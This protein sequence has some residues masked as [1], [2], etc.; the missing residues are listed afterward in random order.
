MTTVHQ[1]RVLTHCHLA[2][3]RTGGAAYGVV[4]DGAVAISGT[5]IVWVGA[6]TDVPAEYR[7]WAQIDLGGRWVL[8]AFIDC[9][10]HLVYAGHRMN[11]FEQR[12]LGASYADIA[13][14]GG[15]ILSTVFA[16]RKASLDELIKQ[17]NPRLTQ[18]IGFGTGTVEIKSGYGLTVRDEIKMLTAARELGKQAQV[19]VSTSFLGAHALPPEFSGDADGYVTMITDEMLPEIAGLG[20]ADAVDGFCETIGFSRAQIR[21]ILEKA[22]D[23]GLPIRLH[24]EQLSH[25]GGAELAA[26]LGALSCDHLEYLDTAGAKAM[27]KAGSVA[28]L[29]PGAFYFLNE[30]QK[31]PVQLL[32][33]EGVAIAVASDCNPGS[34]PTTHLP[35]MCS[36]ACTLFGLSVEEALAGVTR[37]AAKALGLGESLGQI[38]PGFA[39]ELRVWGIEHPAQFAA[40]FGGCPPMEII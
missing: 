26:D 25:L 30:T 28:V 13:K 16:T 34:S 7:S 39:A 11:E 38:A 27:A 29:L 10:T 32:R 23:L 14:Q 33:D 1:H 35:L 8:P 15:G 2:T 21:K 40:Q 5:Q 18:M 12:L 4:R 31:P 24:A 9:H 3:M 17:S 20:L 6:A 36:M 22:C 19:R 37:N